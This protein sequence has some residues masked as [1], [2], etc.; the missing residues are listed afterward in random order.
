M[1][2]DMMRTPSPSFDFLLR[3]LHS[4]LGLLPLGAFLIFH[5]WEN[6]HSRFGAEHYNHEVVGA[7]AGLNYLILIELLVIALPLL[8]HALI[9]LAILGSMQAEPARYRYARNWAYW[10]QRLSGVGILFF[11][12]AHVGMTRLSDAAA[13]ADLFRHMQALLSDPAI[14]ML[15]LGGLLLSVFHL[16]NGLATMAIVWGLTTS[17]QAQRRFAWFCTLFGLV[18]AALGVHG[19]LGFV[20]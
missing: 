20:R 5:L 1:L 17:A 3:R 16:A 4:L 13:R 2:V 6:S 9:G 14:F 12:L 7:L 19:L 15:Y 18:L 8:F 11:L 10:L